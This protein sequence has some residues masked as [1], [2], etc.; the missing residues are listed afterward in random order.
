VPW[1]GLLTDT[2]AAVLAGRA[3]NGTE[4][5]VGLS[6]CH[7][8]HAAA[9]TYLFDGYGRLELPSRHALGQRLASADEHVPF[10]GGELDGRGVCVR[11]ASAEAQM[12]LAPCS[13]DDEPIGELE[14]VLSRRTLDGRRHVRR[15]RRPSH[16]GGDDQSGEALSTPAARAPEEVVWYL[17][18]GNKA[19]WSPSD[20]ALGGSE[21]AVVELSSRWAARRWSVSVYGQFESAYT[22]EGVVYRPWTTF[23][24]DACYGVLILWRAF[25]ALVDVSQLCAATIVHDLHDALIYPEVYLYLGDPSF[26][27]RDA[28]VVHLRERFDVLAVKSRTHAHLLG[29]APSTTRV[30]ITVDGY[31]QRLTSGPTP[32]GASH[33]EAISPPA[34][35]LIL[36]NGVRTELFNCAHQ[37]APVA[38]APYRFVWTS[39]YARGLVPALRWFWPALIARVPGATLHVYYG[40]DKHPPAFQRELRHLLEQRGVSEHGRVNASEIAAARCAAAFHLYFTSTREEIDCI[41]VRES[42]IAG[43]LP[44]IST[45]GVFAEREGVHLQG[46]PE[47]EA[48]QRAAAAQVAALLEEG[49]A[50]LERRRAVLRTKESLDWDAVADMWIT[51]VLK[52]GDSSN[53]AAPSRSSRGG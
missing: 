19:V 5:P 4:V 20:A 31:G 25:G 7:V 45:H 14:A 53:L 12:E 40:M 28:A 48:G 52:R 43:A 26:S 47:T 17:G 18:H 29:V 36:P 24:A 15:H 22:H 1:L 8:S 33:K 32:R 9:Q 2:L 49:P 37:P 21:Q 35:T 27:S 11:T 16:R 38:R 44:L 3:F 13:D 42:L 34:E 41:S 50:E 51:R 6:A 23:R 46:D 30:G 39:D 10:E